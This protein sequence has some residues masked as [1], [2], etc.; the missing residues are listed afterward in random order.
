MR[1]V[2]LSAF[3]IR[4]SEVHCEALRSVDMEF[5]SEVLLFCDIASRLP[6]GEAIA[7]FARWRQQFPNLE[8]SAFQGR[9][10]R[11]VKALQRMAFQKTGEFYA[12][13]DYPH[14]RNPTTY[15]CAGLRVA[16]LP[17]ENRDLILVDFQAGWTI[18]FDH[19]DGLLNDGPYYYEFEEQQDSMQS[20]SDSGGIN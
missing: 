20:P 6:R 10:E 1:G 9:C 7:V 15:R 12:L 14:Q 8:N 13:F 16:G 2:S 3:C 18:V 11:G 4:Q 5:D 17:L 19:E